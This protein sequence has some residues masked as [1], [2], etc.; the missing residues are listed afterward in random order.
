MLMQTALR[1]T[2]TYENVK[3]STLFPGCLVMAGSLHVRDECIPSCFYSLITDHRLCRADGALT[4]RPA[5]QMTPGDAA[6]LLMIVQC[7]YLMA[8]TLADLI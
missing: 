7:P 2:V 6:D 4:L 5:A 3:Q 1:Q 8:D